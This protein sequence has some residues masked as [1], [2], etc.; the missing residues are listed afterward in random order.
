MQ[1][2][3]VRSTAKSESAFAAAREVMPG[4]VSSPVRAFK[5]VGGTPRFIRS[6]AGCTV[7]DVDGNDY[8]DYV[9]SFGPMIVGHTHPRVVAA[10]SD[11]AARG[12]SYGAPT[13]LETELAR[14]V[15]S[16]IPS[17][18]MVRFV[19]SGT[20]A[21]MSAIRLARAATGRDL[22]V[23]CIGCYHGHV[24]GLLVEADRKSVV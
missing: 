23:K 19:N 9:G 12:T 14:T 8:V 13:E 2:R 24:D 22:I 16:A 15:I 3:N 18:E 7:T 4:G 1:Q 5:G 6:A 21:T 11:A 17:V 20:E 10:L